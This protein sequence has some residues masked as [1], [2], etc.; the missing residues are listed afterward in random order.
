MYPIPMLSW[1]IGTERRHR[2][3]IDAL[4][5]LAPASAADLSEDTGMGSAS[6]YPALMEMEE[7]GEVVSVWDR[8]EPD[9]DRPRNRLYSLA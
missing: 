9:P 8:T 3:L 4:K 7:R 5:R 1:I 6:I 2:R